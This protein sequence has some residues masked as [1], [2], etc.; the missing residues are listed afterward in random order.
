MAVALAVESKVSYLTSSIPGLFYVLA[1]LDVEGNDVQAFSDG[2]HAL[3][4]DRE[5][6]IIKVE[7]LDQRSKL[8]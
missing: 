3:K 6:V 5:W 8:E 1:H 2:F 7:L 4:L